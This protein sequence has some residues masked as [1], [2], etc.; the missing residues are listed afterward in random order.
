MLDATFDND[1]YNRIF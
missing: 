1:M